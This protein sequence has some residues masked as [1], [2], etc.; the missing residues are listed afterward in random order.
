MLVFTSIAS[1]S[2][3]YDNIRF[4]SL[5]KN[6]WGSYLFERKLSLQKSLKAYI[7][8]LKYILRNYLFIILTS[9]FLWTVSTI[10]AQASVEYSKITFSI[11]ASKATYVLLY[12][13]LWAIIWNLLSVKMNTNR[14]KFFII[15]NTLFAIVIISFPFL[16]TTFSMLSFLAVILWMVFWISSN[17]VDSYLLKIIWDEDKKEYWASTFW[18]I[19]SIILFCMMFI[20]SIVLEKFWYALLMLLLWIMILLIWIALY[21]KQTYN[22]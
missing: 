5:I 2:L 6:W 9:S 13:A 17:L 7:P 4:S 10:V 14:W 19:F 22:K 20:S 8:D 3:D 15:F 12:S 18:L 1:L 16:A 21:K 11:E